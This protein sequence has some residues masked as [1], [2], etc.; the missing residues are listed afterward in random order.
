MVDSVTCFESVKCSTTKLKYNIIKSC[1]EDDRIRKG[2]SS[3]APNIKLIVGLVVRNGTLM[4]THHPDGKNTRNPTTDTEL[5]P[6]KQDRTARWRPYPNRTPRPERVTGLSI[7]LGFFSFSLSISGPLFSLPGNTG[8]SERRDYFT[9][10]G[11]I[12]RDRN[13]WRRLVTPQWERVRSPVGAAE[14]RATAAAVLSMLDIERLF[15]NTKS[16]D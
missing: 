14:S 10:R 15:V 12:N 13:R 9:Q 1:Q 3:Q 5:W 4:L 11:V 8:T 7:L 6:R 16:C 2:K